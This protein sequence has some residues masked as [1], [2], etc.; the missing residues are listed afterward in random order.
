MAGLFETVY[1]IKPGR[2]VFDMSWEKKFTCDMGELIPICHDLMVPGDRADIGFEFIARA[3][4]MGAPVM[5]PIYC[6]THY[7]FVS[8]RRLCVEAEKEY[9]QTFDFEDWITGGE[10]GADAQ[11]PPTWN[12]TTNTEGSLWDYLCYPLGVDSAGARPVAW[13]QWAY[14][15]I[16]NCWYRDQQIDTAIDFVTNEAIQRARWAKDYF[17]SARTAQ[18]KGSQPAIEGSITGAG[19]DITV[20]S[21]NDSTAVTV[22]LEPTGDDLQ[23]TGYAGILSDMRWNDPGLS[24]TGFDIEDLRLSLATQRSMELA[25]RAGSRYHEHIKSLFNVHDGDDRLDIPEYIGGNKSWLVVS[26]VLQTAATD[27]NTSSQTPQGTMAGHGIAVQSGHI[28]TYRAKE[29]G[30]LFGMFCI[31]P[32]PLYHQGIDRQDLM[33]TKY[34][35][36]H[37]LFQGISEQEVLRREVYCSGTQA[38]EEAVFGYQGRFDEFRQR[39]SR[40]VGD[41]HADYDQ[42]HMCRQFSGNPS[43]NSTFIQ[44]DPRDDW[45][46]SSA[47]DGFLVSFG[48]RIRM[49]RPLTFRA[50]PGLGVL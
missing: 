36:M 30:I 20:S 32:L 4:P 40:V 17:T 37:P 10:T 5:H 1:G 25:S 39:P 27:T 7:F 45:K 3:Q 49:V 18:Q 15:W 6:T 12:V 41:F 47:E 24:I 33:T 29:Y 48:N 34:D 11:T 8:L 2:S 43:L 22:Q 21:E 16:W 38:E 9:S 19:T 50:T 42:W 44:C 14:G 46:A 28:G 26:E 13:K 23:A 31:R 35:F